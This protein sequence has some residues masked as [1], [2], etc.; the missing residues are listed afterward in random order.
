[1]TY[2]PANAEL[3]PVQLALVRV[4][5]MHALNFETRG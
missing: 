5:S 3:T 4:K 1:M 2:N